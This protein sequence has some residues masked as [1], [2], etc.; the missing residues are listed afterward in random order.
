MKQCRLAV[1]LVLAS[2]AAACISTQTQAGPS[3]TAPTGAANRS[4]EE[5]FRDMLLARCVAQA[6]RHSP[7]ALRDAGA[8]A[9]ILVDWIRYDAD[10]SADASDA[11]ISQFLARDYSHPLVEYRDTRFDLLKCLDMYHSSQ[12]ADLANKHVL[13]QP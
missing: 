7:D 5:N 10:A 6:Y 3:A 9:S 13:E 2:F 8:T 12:V 4:S 11:V 1:V